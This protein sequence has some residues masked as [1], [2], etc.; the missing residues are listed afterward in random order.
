M[1]FNF[2]QF[3][4]YEKVINQNPDL[5]LLYGFC[6]MIF[7]MMALTLLAFICRK[8]T[9]IAVIDHFLAPLIC[10]LGLSLVLAILPTV[11]FKVVANDLSGVKLVYTWIAIFLG[12][13]FFSFLNYPMIRKRITAGA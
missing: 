8:L 6:S 12:M 11:I 5:V 1:G 3:F 4:G 10:A 7:G 9:L 13:V 2:N